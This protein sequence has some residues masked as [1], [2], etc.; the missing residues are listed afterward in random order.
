[1]TVGSSYVTHAAGYV[2]NG[3]PKLV[4]SRFGYEDSHTLARFEATGGWVAAAPASQPASSGGSARRASGPGT[5][6]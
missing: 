1:M 2:D 4:T 6:S 3:G 5:W